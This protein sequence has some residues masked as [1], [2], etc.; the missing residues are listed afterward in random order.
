M[1]PQ[2]PVKGAGCERGSTAGNHQAKFNWM[3][4]LECFSMASP[5]CGIYY[6]TAWDW[7]PPHLSKSKIKKCVIALLLWLPPPLCAPASPSYPSMASAA[8]RSQAEPTPLC[9]LLSPSSPCC[10]ALHTL[11]ELGIGFPTWAPSQAAG[12]G[13]RGSSGHGQ[14]LVGH[15]LLCTVVSAKCS[16][17]HGPSTQQET[18]DKARRRWRAAFH[19][20]QHSCQAGLWAGHSAEPRPCLQRC[21]WAR[22]L[23]VG[24]E[25]TDSSHQP[26]V[27]PDSAGGARH[28]GLCSPLLW[29]R[30]CAALQQRVL[31]SERSC[32]HWLFGFL[33]PKSRCAQTPRWRLAF[34]RS[35]VVSHMITFGLSW[36]QHVYRGSLFLLQHVAHYTKYTFASYIQQFYFLLSFIQ[37]NKSA[38]TL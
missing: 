25:G 32:L 1:I 33:P 36:G 2:L 5:K 13:R 19:L 10:S 34:Q 9:R 4:R 29:F 37:Q 24:W 20:P 18:A 30:A 38:T 14:S 12:P 21:C 17:C 35:Q 7:A 6:L 28:K 23:C 22:T 26:L 8:P 3:L 15:R 31:E 27:H 16:C 11:Q